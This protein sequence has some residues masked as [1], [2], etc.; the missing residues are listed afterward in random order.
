MALCLY[1]WS[2]I[3]AV[4]I[5][6]LTRLVAESE[7][8]VA[9]ERVS[10]LIRLDWVP[11]KNQFNQRR[12]SLGRAVRATPQFLHTSSIDRTL[13]RVKS[14]QRRNDVPN[15]GTVGKIAPFRHSASSAA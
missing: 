2:A 7:V 3:T 11:T 1:G 4:Q 10:P 14:S 13:R 8:V 12:L 5:R 6:G 9:G 15:S